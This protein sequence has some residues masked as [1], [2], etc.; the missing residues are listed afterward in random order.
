M[1]LLFLIC[2]LVLLSGCSTIVK[3]TDQAIAINTPDAQG[4]SCELS[5]PA[6]P[7]QTV[8][9]PASV[10]LEK[11]QHNVSVMCRKECFTPGAGIIASSTETMAAGNV[12]FGGVVGLAVDASTGAMNTYQPVVSIQMTPIKGCKAPRRT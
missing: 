9:T 12:I 8:V 4:A 3:G 11:S 10:T 6:I 2:S 5:S 7:T 1:R